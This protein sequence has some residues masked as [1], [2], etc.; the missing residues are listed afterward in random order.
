MWRSV[1]AQNFRTVFQLADQ[2]GYTVAQQ[3]I[4]FLSGS[5]YVQIGSTDFPSGEIR[6]QLEHQ[7][8]CC[9]CCC[10]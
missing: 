5:W 6:T 1:Y 7:V 8:C 10:C 2:T 3:E 4:D 9:Y